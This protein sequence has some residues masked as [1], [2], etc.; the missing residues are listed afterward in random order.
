MPIVVVRS[1]QIKPVTRIYQRKGGAWKEVLLV[2]LMQSVPGQTQPVPKIIHNTYQYPP[3]NLRGVSATHTSAEIAWDAPLQ[4]EPGTEYQVTYKPRTPGTTTW[5]TAVELPWTLNLSQPITALLQSKEYQFTVKARR[6]GADGLWINSVG[7]SN[8]IILATNAAAIT[9]TNPGGATANLVYIVASRGDTWTPDFY[10]GAKSGGPDVIQGYASSSSKNGYGVVAYANA[11]TQLSTGVAALN[12]AGKPNVDLNQ[13]TITDAKIDQIYRKSGGSG[14]PRIEVHPCKINFA[15]NTRPAAYGGIESTF[16][17]PA[18]GAWKDEVQ[19]AAISGGSAD[20]LLDW[21]KQWTKATPPYN[22]LL[23]FRTGGDGNATAGYNG[24][25]IF[26]AANTTATEW[27]LKLW[28]KW[29]YTI[30][31][32]LPVWK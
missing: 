3:R 4:V 24:Y 11:R 25:A 13:V 28:V 1:G 26:R 32:V 21:A 2:E 9:M 14:T 6:M 5:G 10:W 15:S 31:E 23:I 19:F 7:T 30:P 20:P 27:R 18:E 16:T 29:S 17:A 12:P 8:A 22:G